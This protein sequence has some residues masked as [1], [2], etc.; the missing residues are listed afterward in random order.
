MNTL[1]NLNRYNEQIENDIQNKIKQYPPEDNGILFYG[2]STMANWRAN[3]MCY[4]HMAPLKITNTGFGGST[5]E[6]A[7]YNYYR[8]VKPFNPGVIVY[9]EGPNDINSGYSIED[10][11]ATTHRIFE[12]ARQD[13]PNVQFIIVPIKVCPGLEKVYDTCIACNELYKK[14]ADEH[15]DTH[16]INLDK[17]LYDENG[18]LRHDIYVEDMLHHTEEGYEEFTTFVKPVVEKVFSKYKS[19]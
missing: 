10:V 2:S 8:L 6:E 3:N 18:K 14:Y 7:L 16:Y 9:Y 4:K 17:F 11:M 19:L 12:W 1:V 15:E 13:F 5:A